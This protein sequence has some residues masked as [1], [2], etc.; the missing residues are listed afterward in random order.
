MA[1]KLRKIQLVD[2]VAVDGSTTMAEG[3]IGS[4]EN[5]SAPGNTKEHGMS[6]DLKKLAKLEEIEL[7]GESSI[8]D[9]VIAAIVGVA[10]TQRLKESPN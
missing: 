3:V 10:A 1:P 9:D 8:D 6:I 7:G 2:K 4:F 5:Q